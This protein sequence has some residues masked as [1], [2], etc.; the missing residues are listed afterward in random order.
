ML[1]CNPNFICIKVQFR[2]HEI[3]MTTCGTRVLQTC[4]YYTVEKDKDPIDCFIF[5]CSGTA[6]YNK[7]KMHDCFGLNES[8]PFDS[9][10]L[11]NKI[12]I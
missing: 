5:S 10:S 4:E 8:R 11:C 9:I 3:E 12:W 2:E 7:D 1:M 6:L